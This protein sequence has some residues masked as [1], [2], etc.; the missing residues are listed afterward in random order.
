MSKQ[1]NIFFLEVIIVFLEVEVIIFL[2]L[3]Q[4]NILMKKW[5][6]GVRPL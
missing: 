6:D 4:R 2:K 5:T 1:L 3:I